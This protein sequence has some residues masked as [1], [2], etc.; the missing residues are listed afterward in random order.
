[1]ATILDTNIVE[2]NEEQIVK[3]LASSTLYFSVVYSSPN[4]NDFF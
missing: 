4:S 2:G 3:D 1:M